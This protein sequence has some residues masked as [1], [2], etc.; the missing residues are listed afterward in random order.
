MSRLPRRMT[1]NCIV[2]LRSADNWSGHVFRG[3]ELVIAGWCRKHQRSHGR[4]CFANRIG[5]MGGYMTAYG[6]IKP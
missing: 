3:R 5:C 4:V 2:C 6:L 1:R